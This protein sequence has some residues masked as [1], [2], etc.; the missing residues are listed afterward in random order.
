MYELDLPH[1]ECKNI[2]CQQDL[3]PTGFPLEASKALQLWKTG[4]VTC[5]PMPAVTNNQLLQ[6][7]QLLRLPIVPN[8]EKFPVPDA[9]FEPVV[10]SVP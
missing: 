6:Q 10:M 4:T 7:L 1:N 3:L 5:V 2:C 8:S 9:V